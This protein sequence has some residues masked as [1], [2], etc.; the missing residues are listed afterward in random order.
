MAV[1]YATLIVKGQKTFADVPEKI[2]DKV[3]EVLVLIVLNQQN[4]QQ[5]RKLSHTRKQPLYDDYITS[6]AVVFVYRKDTQTIGTV[7]LFNI[8]NCLTNHCHSPYG[9]RGLVT[10]KSEKRQGRKQ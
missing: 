6:E 1:M 5:A 7:Y 9:V 4:N 10:K 8:Y 2:M 3:K